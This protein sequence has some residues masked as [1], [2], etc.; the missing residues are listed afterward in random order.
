MNRENKRIRLETAKSAA[1]RSCRKGRGASTATTAPT[2]CPASTWTPARGTGR[3]IAAA[4]WT[5]SGSGCARTA[6]GR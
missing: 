6:N 2:A 5:P 4:S 3:P 1:G